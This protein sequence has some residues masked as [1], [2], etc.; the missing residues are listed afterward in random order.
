MIKSLLRLSLAAAALA[1]VSTAAL[2]ADL[3]PPPEIRPAYYDWTGPYVGAFAGGLFI[4]SH[5]DARE[6]CNPPGS[7]DRD[8]ELDGASFIGGVLAGWN[9]DAGGWVFGVEG[10]WGWGSS[11]SAENDDP[12]E[13][14]KLN[15]DSLATLRARAGFLSGDSTLIYVTGGA[16]FADTKFEGEITPVGEWADDSQWLTGWTIGGGIE[17][18]FTEGFH[19]RLEYLYIDLPDE[20]YTISAGGVGGDVD[21]QF[22]SIHMF[23]AA[24]SYNFYW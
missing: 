14:T 10:D 19:G 1:S 22:D 13:M 8:P 11:P 18:A 21:V 20:T 15:V 7:C 2:S 17:H 6:F 4:D 24:L 5:Y 23:R 3:E 9:Y 12:L 16:A